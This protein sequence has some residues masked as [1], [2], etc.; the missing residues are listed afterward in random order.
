[1]YQYKSN[2]FFFWSKYKF[3]FSDC[4]TDK[5]VWYKYLF[6]WFIVIRLPK[7]MNTDYVFDNQMKCWLISILL[8]Y[9]WSDIAE[10]V[11]I[12]FD[13]D[14]LHTQRKAKLYA[15]LR[16]LFTL[17]MTVDYHFSKSCTGNLSV[18]RFLLRYFKLRGIVACELCSLNLLFA[19]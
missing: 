2:I 4:I 11:W 5:R 3:S 13:S 8:K 12:C 19:D 6:A 16:H 17:L 14:L 10:W 1:M 9:R 7:R 15:D 18:S